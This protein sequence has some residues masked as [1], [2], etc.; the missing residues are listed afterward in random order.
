MYRVLVLIF[1]AVVTSVAQVQSSGA[2][3]NSTANSQVTG[4]A[5]GE[6]SGLVLDAVTGQPLKKAWVTARVLEKG[7]R[8]GST[9]VTDAQGHF[10][11]RDLDAGRYSLVAQRNGYVNQT[12]GQK[13]AGEQGT[14]ISLSQGQKLSE[15][16]FRLIQGGVISGRIVDEDSEPLSRVQVQALQFR[17]IQGRRRL[18]PLGNALSDDRGEYR[19]FGIRPGQVYIRATLRGFGMYV[20]PGESVDSSAPSETTSYPP[21]FYPNVT[22]ASQA[23]TLTVR[24]G[25]ELRADFSM[26]PQRSY[27]VSGRVVGGVHGTSGRGAWLMLTK[28]GEAEFAIGPGVNTSVREDNTFTF[29][30]V[31][32]GSYNIIAEQQDDK[33]SASAR[34]EVDVREGDVQGLVVALLPQVDV[35]GRVTFDGGGSLAAKPTAVHISLSPEDAQD[36][37][38]S[39][40]AQAK[41]D[42]S[43]TLQAAADERYKIMAFGGPPE[44]YLKSATAAREDVLEKGFSPATSRNLDLVFATG[45]KVSGVIS[46]GDDKPDAGVTV[47]LVPEQRLNGLGDRFRTVTTDQNGRYQVQGL[48]PGSYRIY[49]FERIEPGAYE[50]EEWLKAFADQAHSL[51]L[52]ESAQETLDLKSIPAAAEIQQ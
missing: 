32:P 4:A 41:D 28:R 1:L 16:S 23:S 37:M 46:N 48:R 12:Y 11:L 24:G 45:A 18:Q 3:A 31:L 44:M 13:N 43:F 7:G 9:T 6:I 38:R 26:S 34:I 19:I 10:V 36:F 33:S 29:K 30:Q 40:Y 15:I 8:S 51:R 2:A 27:S 42:G 5:K 50:D 25:D 17:F 21:V 22:D 20:G 47:V 39:A 35:S 14:T 49:A 52:S